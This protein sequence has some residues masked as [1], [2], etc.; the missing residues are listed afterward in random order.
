MQ[1]N[2]H[3]H[4][5]R[6]LLEQE[7]QAGRTHPGVQLLGRLCRRLG[8]LQAE[9]DPTRLRLVQEAAD[10]EHGC[11]RR[12][13][14]ERSGNVVDSGGERAP[15][16]GN[17]RSLKQQRCRVS[18]Q[19]LAVQLLATGHVVAPTLRLHTFYI[20]QSLVSQEECPRISPGAPG[21]IDHRMSRPVKD[22]WDRAPIR[23]ESPMDEPTVLYEIRGQICVITLN[24]PKV[25]NAINRQLRADLTDALRRFDEDDAARVAVLTGAG[26]A[27]CA[28]RDLK[29]RADD[30]AA[31]L[32]ARPLDAMSPTSL[33]SWPHPRKALVGAINGHCLA[34]GFSIAQVCD[35]R[36]AADDA[37]LGITE[38]KVGLM[39]PFGSLLP[40]LI[41]AADALEMILTGDPITAQR[42]AE[43]GFVNRVVPAEQL[44]DTAM[45]MAERIADNAP[46]SVQYAKELIY[47]S[48]D[49]DDV[50][51]HQLTQDLY[52]GLLE[53]EDAKEG[54][55][56]F[57]EKRAPMWLGR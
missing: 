48:L 52:R 26:R 40:R 53:S 17:P 14:S 41:H 24:R 30:N 5:A 25:L 13:G 29:E 35:I 45:E 23:M 44:M 51:L 27:F 39:A 57:V 15:R 43:I 46:L 6:L 11:A 9:H 7:R 1:A 49:L 54:P 8:A 22:P 37:K 4:P 16:G 21:H 12:E 20:L 55:R 47:R 18:A 19:H 2:Q 36:I 33:H 50:R 34:G 56:A 31:G 3:L 28:G 38:A 42:A 10:L 32:Q